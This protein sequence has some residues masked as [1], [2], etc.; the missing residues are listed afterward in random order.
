MHYFLSGLNI[1]N[2]ITNYSIN[3]YRNG[4]DAL[5]QN[6]INGKSLA[7]RPTEYANFRNDE[8][9]AQ[10]IWVR[11]NS[12]L[13]AT[14]SGFGPFIKLSVEKLPFANPVPEFRQ[15]DN[16]G[17]IQDGIYTFNTA[18]LETTLLGSNQTYPVTVT[19]FDNATNT[20]L[21]DVNGVLIAS[22]FPSNFSTKSK[23]IKAVVTNFTT[24]KC[25]DERLIVFIV[26]K[27]PTAT[28]ISPL[29]FTDIRTVCDDEADPTKQDGIFE[30]KTPN[31]ENEIKDGQTNIKITYFDSLGNPL[32]DFLG[33]PIVSPFPSTFKTTSR[34]I[35][36]VVTSTIVGTLCPTASIEFEFTV[37][38]IPKI[39]LKDTGV[40]CGNLAT[41]YI[42]LDAGINDGSPSTGYSYKWFK[43]T[44]EIVGETNY[45]LTKVN[46]A[47][48]YTVTVKTIPEGC[49]STRTITVVASDLAKLSPPTV[50]DLADNN[51]VTV[52]ITGAGDYVFS[53]DEPYGP[54]QES[55]V[56]TNVSAGI[57]QIYVKDLNGCGTVPQEINILGIPKF[58]TPNGDGIHDYWNVK[59][60]SAIFNAK[61]IVTIFDRFGKLIKQISPL[62]QGWNGTYNGEPLPATDYWYSIEFENGKNV[63]GNFTLKR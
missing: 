52:N 51:T 21:K 3:Y 5:A 39:N 33:I 58:F 63:K 29:T 46:Q 59:G 44:V 25:Y 17:N 48:I 55:N 38:K 35:K 10:N 7:I 18:S 30:F 19:Y 41:L 54:F 42:T 40:I 31:L 24:Q 60:V 1:I 50:I 28:P 56:F 36:A 6:D 23:T 34:K 2:T 4:A 11:V 22:P 20:P 8:A 9:N 53:I 57:H 15:C 37:N 16:D 43:D 13:L 49:T 14:C 61:T 26:D 45:T 12:N 32:L 47:G 27:L 62:D